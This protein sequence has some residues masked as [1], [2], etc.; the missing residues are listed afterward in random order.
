[1][2]VYEA[3]DIEES[4]NI[5]VR[6]RPIPSM[7]RYTDTGICLKKTGMNRYR[8]GMEDIGDIGIGLVGRYG[9]YWYIGMIPI[10]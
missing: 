6:V 8:L 4:L 10:F 3:Y 5:G 9:G 1:M 7:S 2:M